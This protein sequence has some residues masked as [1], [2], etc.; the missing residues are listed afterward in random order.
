M[1]VSSVSSGRTPASDIWSNDDAILM[2]MIPKGYET[3]APGAIGSRDEERNALDGYPE[4]T[5]PTKQDK[6]TRYR[7]PERP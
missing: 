1:S 6:V 2:L 7:Y 5:R 4:R 3:A